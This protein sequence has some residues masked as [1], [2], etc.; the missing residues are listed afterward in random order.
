KQHRGEEG[1]LIARQWR[2]RNCAEERI[3]DGRESKLST[4]CTYCTAEWNAISL[5]SV[6]ENGLCKQFCLKMIPEI[7]A[8]VRTIEVDNMIEFDGDKL[9][10]YYT[11]KRQCLNRN[12]QVYALLAFGLIPIDGNC[13][14]QAICASSTDDYL[15]ENLTNTSDPRDITEDGPSYWSSIGQ[16]VPSATETL[17]YRLCSKICL[18]TEIHVQP[19]QGNQVATFQAT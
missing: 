9:G 10:Y 12:H 18:V 4:A 6:I 2:K 13:I 7:S 17:L 15:R 1:F 5:I 3:S 16:S 11:R 14:S 19:F 8:V